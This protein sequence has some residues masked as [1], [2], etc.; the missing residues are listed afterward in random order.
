MAHGIGAGGL[1]WLNPLSNWINSVAHEMPQAYGIVVDQVVPLDKQL[2]AM[3]LLGLG[4][5]LSAM[6]M[7]WV[8]AKARNIRDPIWRRLI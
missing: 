2:P 8:E 7:A 3:R 5:L 4:F 1:Q 6:C